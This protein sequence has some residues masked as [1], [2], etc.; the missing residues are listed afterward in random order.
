MLDYLEIIAHQ[1]FPGAARARAIIGKDAA[2]EILACAREENVDM[3]AIA[4]HGRTGQTAE[5]PGRAEWASARPGASASGPL[6]CD[7]TAGERR[8]RA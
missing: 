1:F 2:A 6:A 3:I 8:A 4:T 7:V 5:A